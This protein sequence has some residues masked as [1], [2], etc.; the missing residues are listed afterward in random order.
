MVVIKKTRLSV[1][2]DV[3]KKEHLCTVGENI[4]WCSHYGKLSG[5][6]FSKFKKGTHFLRFYLFE[7]E[8]EKNSAQA[9]G[10]ADRGRGGLPAERGA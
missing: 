1:V 6:C 3:E 10:A 7:R 5:D 9:G 4:S 8:G 2:Y